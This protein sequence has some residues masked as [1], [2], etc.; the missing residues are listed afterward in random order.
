MPFLSFG[1]AESTTPS[2]LETSLLYPDAQGITDKNRVGRGQLQLPRE[3][4]LPG[5]SAGPFHNWY[6][7][8]LGVRVTES[9]ATATAD[10]EPRRGDVT[11][12]RG[13]TGQYMTIHAGSAYADLRHAER[14]WTEMLSP[15][16]Y[17]VP[18]THSFGC[19]TRRSTRRK[20]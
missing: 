2:A 6:V 7:H 10:E 17:L 15:F 12:T 19:S 3:E 20:E 11:L 4:P 1:I 18:C 5:P 9:R 14:T 8:W 13:S 16:L